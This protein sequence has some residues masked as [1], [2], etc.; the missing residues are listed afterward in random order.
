[1]YMY[2]NNINDEDHIYIDCLTTNVDSG[3][4]IKS[5]F[6][7]FTEMRDNIIL[8]NSSEYNLSIIRFQLSTPN[9]PVMIFPV[10]IEQADPNKGTYSITLKYKTF[11]Y[12][13]FVEF[14]S[15]NI[16]ETVSPPLLNQDF[17]NSYYE[18]YSYNYFINLIN[19]TFQ[20][21]YNGLKALVIAGG[22]ALP[23]TYFPYFDYSLDTGTA[24]LNA[25]ILGYNSTLVNPIE[26]YF[27]ISLFTLF[28]SFDA[29]FYGTSNITNGKNYKFNIV[30]SINN[31]NILT[32]GNAF[33]PGEVVINY[34][35]S[36]QEFPTLAELSQAITSILFTTTLIP[37]TGSLQSKPVLF[38]SNRF[39]GQQS[40]NN[41]VINMITDITVDSAIFSGFKPSIIY[42]ANPYRMV[43]LQSNAVLR[44][45][46]I[47]V[48]YK[49]CY[50][51]VKPFL[52]SCGGSSSIKILFKKKSS[53]N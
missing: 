26:I 38:N 18:I 16:N 2:N 51:N 53:R 21:A 13:S 19:T 11:E 44:S 8:N 37:V 20:N 4:N 43:G 5:E 1:M 32:F 39:S 33:I 29:S 34:I 48:F 41:T 27:N 17:S 24:T 52:L 7:T 12:Q 9:L 6:L 30:V 28:S 40:Q 22:D 10:Q 31:T 23:S 14:V 15:P 46:D 47:S 50:G 42:N 25:D 3:P 49:D 35:Q 36:Y 45:Y